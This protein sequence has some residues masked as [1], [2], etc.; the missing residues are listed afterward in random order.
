MNIFSIIIPLCIAL[1]AVWFS[2][3][4]CNI[5]EY[6]KAIASVKREI[7]TNIQLCGVNVEL[8]DADLNYAK[9]GQISYAPYSPFHDLAWNTYKGALLLKD[10]QMIEEIETAYILINL[11]NTLFHR[12]EDMKWT[13]GPI[14][15][16]IGSN[17]KQVRI[18][19]LNKA[20]KLISQEVLPLLEEIVTRIR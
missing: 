16:I 20:K 13:S 18:D 11:S 5:R 2:H 19:N 10:A 4:I 3:W 8:I 12:I 1:F 7:T 9:K 17:I 14:L 15:A 6:H